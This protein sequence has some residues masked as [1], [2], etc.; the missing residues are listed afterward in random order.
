MFDA[1]AA[2]A[3]VPVGTDGATRWID[4][5]TAR[6]R[7]LVVD[8][9]AD[10]VDP[11]GA[12]AVVVVVAVTDGPLPDTRRHVELARVNGV[13]RWVVYLD[14]T[15]IKDVEITDLVEQE[16]RELVAGGHELPVVRSRGNPRAHVMGG[17]AALAS[18]LDAL[19]L[20]S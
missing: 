12:Q 19:G 5:T 16:V 13:A 15:G 1:V 14:D 7:Y 9:P 20:V 17:P 18:A 10:R 4:T 11:T 3:R 8:A 2:A 6:G